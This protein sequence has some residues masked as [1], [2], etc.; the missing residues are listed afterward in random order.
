MRASSSSVSTSSAAASIS[1]TLPR[2]GAVVEELDRRVADAAARHVDDALEGEVVGRLHG[3][4]EIGERIADFLA[5]VEARAADDAVVEAEGDEAIFEG[6]HLEG[7]AHQDGDLVEPMWPWRWSCSISS[8]TARAS[9]SESQTRRPRPSA[10]RDRCASV[11]SVL[12]SR[13]SLWAIRCEAAPRM[14][15]GR[16]VVALEADHVGAG[17]ILLEAQD[18]VDLGAAPA[19][20]RLVVVADAADVLAP[21]GE[22]PQPEILGDV[23]VLVLVDQHVAEAL[24]ILGEHVLVLAEDPQRLEEQVA[25][26]GGVERLEAILV[27]GVELLAAAVGEGMGIGLRARPS[28]SGRG[29]SSC[30]SSRRAGA[31]ASASRRCPRPG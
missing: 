6:A 30:R 11:N 26:I 31:P 10:R 20:D 4:A 3:G 29:S 8:P 18:V 15:A 25:E 28:A 12:P 9:S 7:G 1:G 24:V 13:L 2:A 14:C 23:G 19:I 27:G 21:L 17:K 5:L 22:Q 16:A